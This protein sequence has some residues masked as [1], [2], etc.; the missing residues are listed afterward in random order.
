MQVVDSP[1][2]NSNSWDPF[3]AFS[4]PATKTEAW[5]KENSSDGIDARADR[6][7]LPIVVAR[8]GEG[9]QR[10]GD[11][12]ASGAHEPIDF[13]VVIGQEDEPTVHVAMQGPE[14]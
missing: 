4:G 13:V 14:R 11:R 7:N 5:A 9:V 8:L 3:I 1:F 2:Q 12:V 10:K 6:D